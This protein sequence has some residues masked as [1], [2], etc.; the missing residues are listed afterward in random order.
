MSVM[1]SF[2][3]K[4]IRSIV[5]FVVYIFLSFFLFLVVYGWVEWISNRHHV[6]SIRW[7]FVRCFCELKV[8][9]ILIISKS[10]LFF[11]VRFTH[12]IYEQTPLIFGEKKNELV[13]SHEWLYRVTLA[14]F[15]ILTLH[16]N[17]FSSQASS[18]D[19]NK[20]YTQQRAHTLED[21]VIR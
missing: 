11:I 15:Q 10:I 7:N 3:H 1:N 17:V 16:A 18:D 12:T 6:Q 9:S 20:T 5:L 13:T 14:P 8:S 21:N 2:F 19:R 4:Q